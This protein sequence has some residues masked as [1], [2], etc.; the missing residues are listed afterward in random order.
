MIAEKTCLTWGRLS[1]IEPETS[2]T[3]TMSFG[4]GV[5]E[6]PA[7]SAEK[8]WRKVPPVAVEWAMN[9]P[10]PVGAPSVQTRPKSRSG[11]RGEVRWE[12]VSCVAEGQSMGPSE[13]GA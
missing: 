6:S 7:P 13:E 9:E 1:V 11:T 8:M 5:A 3:N 4:S 10:A 12:E 2:R